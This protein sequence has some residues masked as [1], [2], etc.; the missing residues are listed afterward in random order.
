MPRTNGLA[1]VW[2]NGSLPGDTGDRGEPGLTDR[3]DHR[4]EADL[5]DAVR[6]EQVR[7]LYA[8]GLG[9]G[10]TLLISS[11]LGG[12]LLWQHTLQILPGAVWWGA[13]AAHTGARAWLRRAYLKAKPPLAGWRPWARRF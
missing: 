3:V 8:E 5:V 12:I 7:L 10:S 13:V 6:S 4:D 9:P 2:S 1:W 11:V